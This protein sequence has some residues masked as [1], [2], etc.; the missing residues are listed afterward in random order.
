MSDINS[1]A[2]EIRKIVKAI[3][4]ISFQINLLALNA[5]VEA[6]RAGKYGKGFAVVAE[7]VRNL[8][9]R[10][11]GSVQETNRMVNEAIAN[12]GRGN[13]L[14]EVTAKQL[15]EI[16]EGSAKV[17]TLAE[18]VATAGKEQ[19]QG[20]EQITTGLT[21]IDQVTQS[22]TASAEESASAAE[23][24]SSQSQQLKGMLARFKLRAREGKLSN[25]DVMRMLQ[26]ELGRQGPGGRSGLALRLDGQ[27]G[28]THGHAALGHGSGGHGYAA[29]AVA[30]ASPGAG[31]GRARAGKTGRALDPAEV[32]A[33]DDDDF[34]K[35]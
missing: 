17:A 1:S 18:E 20:L 26:S 35:F 28:G 9:V 4:D 29:Q 14:V 7:E 19:A 30:A 23:E 3:D 5:N 22:N 27:A 31:A 24:L 33:L 32:I 6:A 11:A 8:A 16:V 2:E 25:E 10:S 34:G 21:Q 13:G 12:I 15:S